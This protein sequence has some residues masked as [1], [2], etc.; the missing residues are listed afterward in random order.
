MERRRRG[1]APGTYKSIRLAK[2]KSLTGPWSP[3]GA[4]LTPH[5]REAP[6][7]VPS[8]DGREWYLYAEEYPKGYRMYKAASLDQPGPWREVPLKYKGVIRHGCVIRIDESV[9]RGLLAADNI[10]KI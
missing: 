5:W 2:S 7:L 1:S 4:P 3:P 9:Y 8:L 10:E 6:S